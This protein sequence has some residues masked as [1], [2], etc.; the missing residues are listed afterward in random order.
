[1]FVAIGVTGESIVGCGLWRRHRDLKRVQELADSETENKRLELEKQIEELRKTNLVLY[2]KIQ[3]RRLNADTQQQIISCLADK[4]KGKVLVLAGWVDDESKNFAND[5]SKVLKNSGF[6]VEGYSQPNSIIF[7]VSNPG[8][9]ICVKN[10]NTAP[11]HAQSIFDC[12]NKHGL[13]M[14][15]A[16]PGNVTLN[17]GDVLLMI[18]PRF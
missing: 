12:F 18:G 6:T 8:L 17:D 11:I 10:A 13:D 4:P 15:V 3:P 9:S 14:Q 5:I 1:V 16:Q 7:S 2:S